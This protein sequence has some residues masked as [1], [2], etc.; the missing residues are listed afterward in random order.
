MVQTR[1]GPNNSNAKDTREQGRATPTRAKRQARRLSS[2]SS[3]QSQTTSKKPKNARGLYGSVVGMSV[4][5]V[6]LVMLI[7]WGRLCAILCTSAWLYF[8]PRFSHSG[9]VND[10]DGPKT[11]LGDVDLDSE[12]YKKKVIME[13]LLGRN[14]RGTM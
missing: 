13:G 12:V 10:D 7:F 3:M 11:K 2:S 14:H 6:T 5:V 1:H 4:L 9:D 8:I